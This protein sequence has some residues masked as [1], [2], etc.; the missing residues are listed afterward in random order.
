M[1]GLENTQLETCRHQLG[2]T[3]QIS[4][5]I[6]GEIQADCFR[7]RYK[8]GVRG[9]DNEE[10][11]VQTAAAL[12]INSSKKTMTIFVTCSNYTSRPR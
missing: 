8:F 6:S 12:S 9:V 5:N 11:F 4:E 7:L 10:L 1:E 2:N 3:K